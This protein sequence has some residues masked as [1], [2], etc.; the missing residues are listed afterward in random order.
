MTALSHVRPLLPLVTAI[1]LFL[2]AR[3]VRVEDMA[4][5]GLDFVVSPEPAYFTVH[6]RS[7]VALEGTTIT[8]QCVAHI[9]DIGGFRRPLH[10]DTVPWRRY[11]INWEFMPAPKGDAEAPAVNI[12]FTA[13]AKD[14]NRQV[15]NY[16]DTQDMTINSTLTIAGSMLSDS[17]A[18]RCAV[19]DWELKYTSYHGLIQ[20]IPRGIGGREL[21]HRLGYLCCVMY[22]V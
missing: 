6:P 16:R 4:V 2:S 9:V 21:E 18:Y 13:A 3:F 15:V 22:D 11:E 5:E 1:Y 7:D 10:T 12:H 20:I 19:Q 8:L 14:D 17:G